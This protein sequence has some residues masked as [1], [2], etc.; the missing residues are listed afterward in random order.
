MSESISVSVSLS[1]SV[2]LSVCLSLCGDS[3]MSKC[4]DLLY[5]TVNYGNI[6]VYEVLTV[7]NTH[8][9]G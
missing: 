9:R 5:A 8:L 3:M 6:D 4:M 2:C 7:Q 1:V